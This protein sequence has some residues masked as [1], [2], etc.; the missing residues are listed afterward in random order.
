[1]ILLALIFIILSIFVFETKVKIV[2]GTINKSTTK[3]KKYLIRSNYDIIHSDQ[4]RKKGT[5]YSKAGNIAFKKF[6][7]KII[8]FKKV[9]LF[10]S[11]PSFL[12]LIF[13]KKIILRFEILDL[14]DTRVENINWVK[15]LDLEKI[16][17]NIPEYFELDENSK[18]KDL[19]GLEK[20]KAVMISELERYSFNR[21]KAI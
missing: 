10:T 19:I 17:E 7:I 4:F 9:A 21:F 11:N 15:N 14:R 2:V 1:M 18:F 6:I 12:K 16:K 20:R 5:D 3:E 13:L 8:K